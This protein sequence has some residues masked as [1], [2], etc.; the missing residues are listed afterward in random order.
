VGDDSTGDLRI[1]LPAG[2]CIQIEEMIIIKWSQSNDPGFPFGLLSVLMNNFRHKGFSKGL[3]LLA[4]LVETE[5]T[6]RKR[7]STFFIVNI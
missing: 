3:L 6:S 1:L 4:G 5:V 2:G 7:E